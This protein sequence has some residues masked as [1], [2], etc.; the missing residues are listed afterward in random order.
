MMRRMYELL[1]GLYPEEVRTSFAPEMSDVFAQVADDR[2]REGW[3][4]FF[5]FVLGELLGLLTGAAEAHR[6]ARQPVLDLRLMRPPG[7]SRQLYA[8]ALDEVI[9]AQRLVD[10]N[11]RRM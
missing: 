9:A 10:F 1:L 11:L 5:A 2:R 4:P 8:D 7:V 6:A 3:F